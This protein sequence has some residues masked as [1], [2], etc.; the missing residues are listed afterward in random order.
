MDREDPTKDHVVFDKVFSSSAQAP[1]D[2]ASVNRA[3]IISSDI[4]RNFERV[5][6]AIGLKCPNCKGRPLLPYDASRDDDTIKLTCPTCNATVIE[7]ELLLADGDG[8]GGVP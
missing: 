2:S 8:E 7:I 3:E 6:V 1:S 5:S 4:V